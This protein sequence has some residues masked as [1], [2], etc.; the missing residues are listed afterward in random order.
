MLPLPLLGGGGGEII[1][2]CQLRHEKA[3]AVFEKNHHFAT[4]RGMIDSGNACRWRSGYS[5]SK[6]QPTDYLL[7]S[8]AKR[9]LGKTQ[10]RNLRVTTLRSDQS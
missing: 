9:Y 3:N 5:V 8:V 4:N 10:W 6:D 2:E 1:L 7:I